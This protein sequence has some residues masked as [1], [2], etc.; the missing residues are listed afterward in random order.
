M[1]TDPK[2]RTGHPLI[3]IGVVLGV[4]A[5]ILIV[6]AVG[7]S[8]GSSAPPVPTTGVVTTTT[9]LVAG[10]T[11][12]QKDV[13]IKPVPTTL[14]PY[15]ALTSYAEVVGKVASV[16]LPNNTF[17]TASQVTTS[18][19]TTIAPVGPSLLAVP[20]GDVA[21]AIPATVGT[22]TA[23]GGTPSLLSGSVTAVGF[24]IEKGSAIDIL[25]QNSN[26]SIEYAFQ[27]LPIIAVGQYSGTA[28]AATSASPSVYVVAVSLQTAQALDYMYKNEASSIVGYAL[29]SQANET[30]PETPNVGSSSRAQFGLNNFAALFPGF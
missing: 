16:S 15:Q 17:I 11:I 4:V 25:V 21:I 26:G 22:A 5:A 30:S 8:K 6:V 13:T 14:V 2:A 29:V 12:T 28:A 3:I 18:G 19:S 10:A 23:S 27:N 24:Y 9:N 1:V 7:S 20:G